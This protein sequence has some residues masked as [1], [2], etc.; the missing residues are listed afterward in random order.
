MCGYCV[1]TIHR[2]WCDACTQDCCKKCPTQCSTEHAGWVQCQR[3]LAVGYGGH[4]V[5][6]PPSK[7]KGGDV[8][9]RPDLILRRCSCSPEQRGS[10]IKRLLRPN[11]RRCIVARHTA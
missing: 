2:G 1:I 6:V 9:F 4:E 11:S 8:W 10:A 3:L 7:T 5:A